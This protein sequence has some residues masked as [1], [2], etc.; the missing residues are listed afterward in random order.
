MPAARVRAAA[1]P[2]QH[3]SIQ[4]ASER[5]PRAITLSVWA[6]SFATANVLNLIAAQVWPLL[7]SHF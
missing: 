3:P 2:A 6:N 5:K 7:P 1:S 4:E